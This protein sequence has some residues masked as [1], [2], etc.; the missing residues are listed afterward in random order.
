MSW[1]RAFVAVSI[2]LG[3]PAEAVFGALDEAGRLHVSELAR[4]VA[5]GDRNARARGIAAVLAELARDADAM[6]IA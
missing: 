6:G 4:L 5:G 3:E 2:T 1:E